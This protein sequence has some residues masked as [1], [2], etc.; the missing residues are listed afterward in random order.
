M[1]ERIKHRRPGDLVG[2]QVVARLQSIM[3]D[4][5]TLVASGEGDDRL[6]C[7]P[8]NRF[9]VVAGNDLR[10]VTEAEA[11]AFRGQQ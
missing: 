2:D 8:S 3:I 11:I 5:A 10:P 9:F 1:T 7:T 6:Y 4:G